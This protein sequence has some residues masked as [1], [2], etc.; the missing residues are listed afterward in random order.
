[1]ID[2][3]DKLHDVEGKRLEGRTKLFIKEID[4]EGNILEFGA[5][6]GFVPTE[7]GTLFI[8]D[9]YVVDQVDKLQFKSGQLIVKEGMTLEIPQKS[10]LEIEKEELLKRLAELENV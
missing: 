6:I 8:V 3:Y 9:D 2:V 10:A 4:T 5:G 7:T 1:M